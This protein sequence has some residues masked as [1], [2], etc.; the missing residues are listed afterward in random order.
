MPKFNV[1]IN[2]SSQAELLLEKMKNVS[3]DDVIDW[4]VNEKKIFIGG[5]DIVTYLDFLKNKK[6]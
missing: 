2:F 5:G 1:D 3:K 4:F 6:S